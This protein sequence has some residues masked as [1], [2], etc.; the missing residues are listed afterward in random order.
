[1][2]LAASRKEV[3]ASR[4]KLSDS[5]QVRAL[6]GRARFLVE[7]PVPGAR[8]YLDGK[9]FEPGEGRLIREFMTGVLQPGKRYSLNLKVEWSKEGRPVSVERQLQFE[10]DTEQRLYANPSSSDSPPE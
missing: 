1:A 8:L 10:G 7:V 4:R 9:R 2:T 5:V 3:E 6:E